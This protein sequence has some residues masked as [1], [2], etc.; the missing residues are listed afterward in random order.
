[1]TQTRSGQKVALVTG[2]GRGIGQALALELARQGVKVAL[3]ARSQSE[4]DEVVAQIKKIGGKYL[5]VS[6]D[7]SDLNGIEDL[8]DRITT[9]LGP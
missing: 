6:F 5:A 2:A 1:M 3:V 9:E 8:V 7:L 4:I